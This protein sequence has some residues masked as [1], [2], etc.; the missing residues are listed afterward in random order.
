MEAMDVLEA[1]IIKLEARI[2]ALE[3]KEDLSATASATATLDLEKSSTTSSKL[4][5][6][7]KDRKDIVSIKPSFMGITLDINELWRRLKG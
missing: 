6:A 3:G 2:V 1:G 5:S 7:Q 4:Q